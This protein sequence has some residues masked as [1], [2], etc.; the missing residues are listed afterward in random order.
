MILE[1]VVLQIGDKR[2]YTWFSIANLAAFNNG[3]L[4]FVA[5]TIVP[6]RT[7]FISLSNVRFYLL[8]GTL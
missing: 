8:L 1:E 3:L 6:S 7:T 2:I 4:F 5:L